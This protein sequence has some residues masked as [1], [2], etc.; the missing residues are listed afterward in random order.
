[1]AAPPTRDGFN[2]LSQDYLR[3]PMAAFQPIHQESPVFFIPALQAWMVTRYEDVAA[4]LKDTDTFS[5]RSLAIYPLDDELRKAV[6]PEDDRL[7]RALLADIVV[8]VDPPAHTNIRRMQQRSFTRQRVA[9]TLEHITRRCDELIDELRPRGEA[10]LMGDFN[11]RFTMRVV[12]DM[13]GLEFDDLPR[14]TRMVG[15][16][17]A[18]LVPVGADSGEFGEMR[19]QIVARFQSLMDGYRYFADFVEARR[20]EPRDD[21]A[22]EMI[23]LR[24]SDGNPAMTVEAVVAHMLGLVTAGTDTTANLLG[25]AVRRLTE[26]TAVRDAAVADPSKWPSV[27]EEALR[28]ES[29]ADKTYRVTLR[30]TEI[31]GQAIPAGATVILSFSAANGDASVFP[32]PLKFDIDRP[33]IAN[34]LA[35]GVGR[36]FCVGA[37]LVRPEATI[38]LERLYARLPGLVADL[39]VQQDF[40]PIPAMRLRRSLPVTWVA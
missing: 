14:F 37:P 32:D 3:D 34:S 7:A 38:A 31:R 11:T 33:E 1:M 17:F 10:E 25:S 27:V 40:A 19:E 9:T 30:D 13:L 28:R 21:M 12:G 36:H 26:E 24:D 6:P 20:Q 16:F 5:S 39:S 15:D 23:A 2:L 8:L 29:P 35:F 4:A 22:S 18:L